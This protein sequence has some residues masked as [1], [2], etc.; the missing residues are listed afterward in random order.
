LPIDADRVH[1]SPPLGE[2][3]RGTEDT[4]K[5]RDKSIL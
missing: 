2:H 3:H 5:T 1:E 4:E